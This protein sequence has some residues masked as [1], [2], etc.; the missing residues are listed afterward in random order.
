MNKTIWRAIAGFVAL[1]VALA[2]LVVTGSVASAAPAQ[3]WPIY[4]ISYD[5]TIYELVD[6]GG[7]SQIPVPLSY[8]K[9]REVYGF[10]TPQPADTNFV[11]YPWSA[12]IYAVTFWPGGE[13]SWMWTRLSYPQWQ[14]AGFPSARNAGWIKNSYEY[15][16]ASSGEIFVLGEDGVHHKLTG[17]EWAAS[18]YR[19]YV[20]RSPEG[21]LKLSWDGTIV[22]M[23]DIRGGH[24]HAVS[25]GEWQAEAFP[26][27]QTVNR[28]GGD[29]FY[30]NYNDSTIW[31]AGPGMNRPVS[32]KEWAAAG[33]PTP[34]V[35]NIPARPVSKRCSDF[36]TWRDAQNWFE[37]YYDAYGDVAGLDANNNRIACEALLNH[38]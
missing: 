35:R 31:Y 5:Q 13:D 4:K 9:W 21:F 22:R 16:W 14:T 17:P 24:G 37:Y 6:N 23:P 38:S 32:Y 7:G 3:Q 12:T 8:N 19:P 11:K 33:Q 26:T 2:G 20:E 30:R 28:I 18:G 34:G 36:A 27:P 29:S 25:Y 10:K 15:K 1:V